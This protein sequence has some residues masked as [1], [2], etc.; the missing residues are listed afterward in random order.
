VGLSAGLLAGWKAGRVPTGAHGLDDLMIQHPILHEANLT[1]A[2]AF[3]VGPET[4][5]MLSI[6]GP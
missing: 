1:S 5:H 6:G 4:P 2:F 3:P